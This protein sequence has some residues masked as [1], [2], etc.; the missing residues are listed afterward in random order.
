MYLFS[1]LTTSSRTYRSRDTVTSLCRPLRVKYFFQTVI[2]PGPT[3][4]FPKSKQ[5]WNALSSRI[6]CTKFQEN[7]NTFC[8][9]LYI[10]Y[11]GTDGYA[12]FEKT[13]ISQELLKRFSKL[14]LLCNLQ[15]RTHDLAPSLSRCDHS[16]SRDRVT[17][18]F[19]DAL[20]IV[21][22]HHNSKTTWASPPN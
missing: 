1:L 20:K 6:F 17:S 11:S 3:E 2:S 7:G 21:L 16:P 4:I 8:F 19:F 14:K 5:F 15:P 22:N 13:P 12:K 10:T 18:L 9:L